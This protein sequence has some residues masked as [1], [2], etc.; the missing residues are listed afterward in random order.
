MNIW[1]DI[2][3]DRIKADE[4]VA[5]I[6]IAKGS[7]VKY[8]LDKETGMIMFDRLLSTSM[9]YPANY[10]F[11]PRT[12]GGDGDPLDVLVITTEPLMPGVLVEARP[13]GM[14]QMIDDGEQDEKIIAVASSDPFLKNVKS[15]DD[16]PQHTYNEMVHF[17]SRYKELQKKVTEIK[18]V[19]GMESARKVIEESLINYRAEFDRN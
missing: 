15:L 14:I 8:E 1:H 4:F 9:V 6:E 12:L 7:K 3:A 11:I 16:L 10:G 13:I 18:G 2:E 17:F 5:V 19:E